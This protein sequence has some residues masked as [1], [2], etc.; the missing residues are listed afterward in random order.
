MAQK[1]YVSL[2]KLSTFLDNLKNVFA[3]KIDINN[4]AD[5][6]H[7][8]EIS[9]ITNL[10]STLTNIEE[11]MNTYILN[12]D[13]SVLEFDISKTV[14]EDTMSAVVGAATIGTMILGNS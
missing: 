12:V 4:K 2:S 14:S 3:T 10:Q 6:V 1:K 7:A 8:H 9:D 11:N 5:I 13:Y